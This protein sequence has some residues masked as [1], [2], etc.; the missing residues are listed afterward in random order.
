MVRDKLKTAIMKI[1]DLKNRSKEELIQIIEKMIE[2]SPSNKI[3]LTHLLSGSKPNLNK[4]LKLIE[5]EMKNHNGSYRSA[6]QLYTLFI[7]SNPD[8]KDILTLSFEI[9]PY[10]ME[11]LD[12]YQDNLD[13]LAVMTNHI[14]GVSCKYSVLLNQSK[15]IEEL[16]SM[17]RKYDFSE[18]INQT[19]MDS[20]YTYMP[21]EILDQLLDE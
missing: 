1:N 12:T 5:K 6:Y 8:Q 4:T 3:L 15:I 19:F 9:L 21:E 17:L 20:F 7:Q 16:S 10:F 2:N 14:F 11:E 18:Y 13:D